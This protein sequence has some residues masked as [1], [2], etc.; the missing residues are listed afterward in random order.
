[1]PDAARRAEP[2]L[3]SRDPHPP[4]RTLDPALDRL[5]RDAHALFEAAV[6]GVT[7]AALLARLDLRTLLRRPP[8]TY[9]RIAVLGAG[10]AALAMAAALEPH[11]EGLPVHGTVTVP[12]GYPETRPPGLHPP[13]RVAVRTAGHP[14]PDAA[15]AAAGRDALA[16]ANR[17]GPDDLLIVLLS[18]GGSALWLVPAEPLTLPDVQATVRLLL[19]SGA[20]IAAVN[21]VRKH[22]AQLGGGQ[23]ARAAAPAEVL[24]LALSDVPDDDPATLASGPTV[25]DPSTFAEACAVLRTAGVWDATPAPVRAHLEAGA[26]GALSETPKPGEAAFAR[27]AFHRLGSNRDALDAAEAEARRRGYRVVRLPEPLTGEAREAGRRLAHTTRTLPSNGPTCLL[28]GGETTVTVRGR[29]LGGRNQE[30][31]LAAALALEDASRPAVVLSGGTD[32]LDGPTD[33]AGAWATPETAA[34]ARA[35]GLDPLRHLAENDAY[36]F[37]AALGQLLRTGPTHTNAMDVQLGLAL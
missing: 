19:H 3:P 26:R 4:P 33:A 6:A 29:G 27:T 30:L 20:D 7:P 18:G 13:R 34:R 1:M 22:L 23:L 9:R 14:V 17:L 28:A 25:P 32:G 10:K 35:A 5:A 21:A 31:A 12:H 37:F 24:T 2:T 36:P 15:S 16:T 8:A 11:L